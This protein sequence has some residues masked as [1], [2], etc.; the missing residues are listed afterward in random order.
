ML[1]LIAMFSIGKTIRN[2]AVEKR[3]KPS[4]FI[5]NMVLL[6]LGF[7]FVGAFIGLTIFNNLMGGYFCGL[8]G[9]A[10]GGYLG[11]QRVVRAEPEVY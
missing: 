2:I 10:I 3:L 5:V 9:A 7:E 8:A 11:Y 6:W 1:E 4:P